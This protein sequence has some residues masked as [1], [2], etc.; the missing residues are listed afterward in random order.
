MC[1]LI[2]SKG[3]GIDENT[4]N[5]THA[6]RTPKPVF[7]K[8]FD[9]LYFFFLIVSKMKAKFVSVLFALFLAYGIV[10][11]ERKCLS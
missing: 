6:T 8:D 10:N 9:L 5:Q 2:T 11:S 7:D 1:T 4:A 3:T